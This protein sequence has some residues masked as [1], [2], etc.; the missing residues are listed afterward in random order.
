M[1]QLLYIFLP[2]KPIKASIF[3]LAIASLALESLSASELFVHKVDESNISG[4]MTRLNQPATN[5]QPNQLIFVTPRF[6]TYNPHT[7]GVWYE[8]E[9]GQWTIYNEDRTPLPM[10]AE[11]N[12]LSLSPNT[13][14][15]FTHTATKDNTVDYYTFISHPLSDYDPDATL[16]ITPNWSE[17]YVPGPLGVW[18]DGE[19]W[20]IYRQDKEPLAAGT[21]FN[22]LVL[23][24]GNT[25]IVSNTHT[26]SAETETHKATPD[27]TR[28]HIT[29]LNRT[30]PD[31]IIFITHNWKDSGPYNNDVPGVWY[32]GSDWTILNQGRTKL[33]KDSKFNASVFQ[34]EESQ[35]AKAPQEAVDTRIGWLQLQNQADY[36]VDFQVS[37]MLDGKTR[38]TKTGFIDKGSAR[39]FRIPMRASKIRIIGTGKK[40]G[41]T[42]VLVDKT[43]S[44]VPNAAYE[45]SQSFGKQD[46]KETK[47]IG[48][49]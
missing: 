11:F 12:V 20:S 44:K 48:R 40:G 43:M 41:I 45:I 29:T 32:D 24:N 15:A 21:R 30:S 37:F 39:N 22:V 31:D 13:H 27:N 23:K 25:S 36:E 33:E 42:H 9:T 26:I 19:R 5:G 4:H 6:G 47:A 28:G 1:H 7:V 49:E 10:D 2:F 18:Y 46:L 35:P 14:Q 17:S 34:I 3:A 8:D 38:G 16:L